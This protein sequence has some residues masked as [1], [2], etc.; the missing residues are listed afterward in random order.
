MN[1]PRPRAKTQENSRDES[2]RSIRISLPR[3]VQQFPH[4]LQ[5][6]RAI[7]TSPVEGCEDSAKNLVQLFLLVEETMCPAS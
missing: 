1:L 6:K 5:E 7:S 4:R 3:E 2:L